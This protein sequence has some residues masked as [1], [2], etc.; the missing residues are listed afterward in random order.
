MERPPENRARVQGNKGVGQTKQT[1]GYH[2]NPHA[3]LP[4]TLFHLDHAISGRDG[5]TLSSVF[6]RHPKR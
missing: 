4:D 2:S 6:M 5:N 3:R 1:G